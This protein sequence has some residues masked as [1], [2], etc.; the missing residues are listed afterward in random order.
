MHDITIDHYI[1]LSKGGEDEIDNYRLAHFRCN[2][3]KGS[4]TPEEFEIYQKGGEFVE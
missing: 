3:M 4:M 2:R 1:P